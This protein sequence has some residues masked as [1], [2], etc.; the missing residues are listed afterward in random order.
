MFA[1]GWQAAISA[2]FGVGWGLSLGNSAL[3]GLW[4]ASMAVGC[5]L[6]LVHV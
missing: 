3:A 5:Y 1:C 4:I 2:L 6:Y